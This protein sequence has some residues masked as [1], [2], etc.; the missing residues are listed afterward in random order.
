MSDFHHLICPHCQGSV[1][2]YEMNCR[3]FRHGIFLHNGDQIPPHAS[4][5]DCDQWAEQGLLAGCGKPFQVIRQ[6]DGTELAIPCD[7]I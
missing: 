7:Y 1:I 3:I 6:E 5:I 4:K 2:V